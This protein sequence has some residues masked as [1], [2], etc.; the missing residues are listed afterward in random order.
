MKRRRTL[1][2]SGRAARAPRTGKGRGTPTTVARRVSMST[3]TDRTA[4]GATLAQHRPH[5][6]PPPPSTSTTTPTK[7]MTLTPLSPLKNPYGATRESSAVT[8]KPPG[9]QVPRRAN[10]AAATS[11]AHA[12][13]RG[14]VTTPTVAAASG[15]AAVEFHRGVEQRRARW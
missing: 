2:G 12:H 6:D 4:G 3:T 15:R 13:R 11:D 14:P 5:P 8:G 1:S 10:N 7:A 9:I